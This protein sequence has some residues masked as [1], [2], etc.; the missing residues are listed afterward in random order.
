MDS[1]KNDPDVVK[2]CAD[3]RRPDVVK[4]CSLADQRSRLDVA[5]VRDAIVRDALGRHRYV[6]NGPASHDELLRKDREIVER[7]VARWP[8]EHA[9]LYASLELP[10]YTKK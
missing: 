7:A 6:I 10:R 1:T 5:I 9:N 3:Q 2:N 4:N 8:R